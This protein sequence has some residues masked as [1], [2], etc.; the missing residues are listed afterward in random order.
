MSDLKPGREVAKIAKA[1]RAIDK[2]L[3]AQLRKDIRAAATPIVAKA[4][5]NARSLPVRS[6][7]ANKIRA[8]VARGVGVQVKT[9]KNARIR[10]VTRMPEKSEAIIP[11]GFDSPKGFRHPVFGNS[12]IWVSQIPEKSD[13]FFNAVKSEAP[14]AIAEVKLVLR[15]AAKY[16]AKNGKNK[17]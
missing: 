16:V 12:D 10:I 9:G 4:K 6:T 2:K 3:P 14:F 7:D 13:W 1:L 8:A 15:N 5:A 11:R 17:V